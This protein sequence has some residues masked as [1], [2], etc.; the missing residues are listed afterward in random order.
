MLMVNQLKQQ[1]V[2]DNIPGRHHQSF[3]AIEANPWS[4]LDMENVRDWISQSLHNFHP[5]TFTKHA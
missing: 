5:S 2:F 3:P 4:K 1:N